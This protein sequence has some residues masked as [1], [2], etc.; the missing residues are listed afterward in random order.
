MFANIGLADS[1]DTNAGDGQIVVALLIFDLPRV[2]H[3]SVDFDCEFD[4]PDLPVAL[5][6]ARIETPFPRTAGEGPGMG[7]VGGKGRGWAGDTQ[8][9]A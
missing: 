3:R 9:A 1:D 5:N 4:P 8:P 6:V 7:A 2:V